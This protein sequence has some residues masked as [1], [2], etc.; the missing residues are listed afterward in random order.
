MYSSSSVSSVILYVRSCLWLWVPFFHTSFMVLCY[1]N[2][3]AMQ[4]QIQMQIYIAIAVK[5]HN[6]HMHMPMFRFNLNW[7]TESESESETE[8]ESDIGTPYQGPQCG[9]SIFG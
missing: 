3:N 1:G 8:S 2:S 4:M 6:L 7:I 5:A 9:I